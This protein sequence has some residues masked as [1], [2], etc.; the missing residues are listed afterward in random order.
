VKDGTELLKNVKELVNYLS[1]ELKANGVACGSIPIA[2]G[3]KYAIAELITLYPKSRVLIL[4]PTKYG[5]NEIAHKTRT[6]HI[7][8]ERYK[9][10]TYD[11][12]LQN[13]TSYKNEIG[14]DYDM[15]IL[16]EYLMYGTDTAY[17]GCIKMIADIAKK[18]KNKLVGITSLKTE[19][20]CN[21][22]L[23]DFQ[24]SLF[25]SR[26]I[27]SFSTLQES[28]ECGNYK[29][30]KY[31][32]AD[33]YLV[34]KVA[35][36]RANMRRLEGTKNETD[37]YIK[38]TKVMDNLHAYLPM[39]SHYSSVLKKAIIDQ[40]NIKF[41]VFISKNKFEMD[42]IRLHNLLDPIYP[43]F[44]VYCTDSTKA[45]IDTDMAA[46]LKSTDTST[47]RFLVTTEEDIIDANVKG[48]TGAI[49]LAPTSQPYRTYL[50]LSIALAA[51]RTDEKCIPP[52]I[53]D[54][55]DNYFNAQY[56][57]VLKNKSIPVLEH[58]LGNRST[59]EMPYYSIQEDEQTRRYHSIRVSY[60]QLALELKDNIYLYTLYKKYEQTHKQEPGIDGGVSISGVQLSTWYR[61]LTQ[62]EKNSLTKAYPWL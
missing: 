55:V 22:E 49:F 25:K 54:M 7:S 60:D 57:S 5:R 17:S 6:L 31:T 14:E 51:C 61:G 13:K 62:G 29:Y 41:L 11:E 26:T 8:P 4:T 9:I 53:V 1:K 39:D 46:F 10:R 3:G 59:G 19:H 12:I 56:P 34:N 35:A 48:C 32:V 38:Y 45:N 23:L 21:K 52:I 18:S 43:N 50:Q 37:K 44:R 47:P 15:F 27:E 58:E 30:P 16:N 20:L 2:A 28:V 42:V 24:N 40:P 36:L 33:L